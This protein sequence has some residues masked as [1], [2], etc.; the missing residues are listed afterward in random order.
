MDSRYVKVAN[1]ED[2]MATPEG[3]D[4]KDGLR[5]KCRRKKTDKNFGQ[6]YSNQGRS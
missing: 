1:L 2:T 4:T 5:R 6:K 3:K